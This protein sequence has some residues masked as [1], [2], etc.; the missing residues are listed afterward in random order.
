MGGI[1]SIN[2]LNL[3]LLIDVLLNNVIVATAE[4]LT[5]GSGIRELVC[6]SIAFYYFFLTVAA[7]RLS[8][9]LGTMGSRR[10]NELLTRFSQMLITEMQIVFNG[11]LR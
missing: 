8:L 10:V 6:L 7:V 1:D 9:P 4:Y 3:L 11:L 2:T 5:I